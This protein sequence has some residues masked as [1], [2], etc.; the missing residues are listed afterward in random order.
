MSPKPMSDEPRA[1]C[2]ADAGTPLWFQV[3][4]RFLLLL[5]AALLLLSLGTR[6][7]ASNLIVAAFAVVFLAQGCA[8]FLYARAWFYERKRVYDT[9]RELSSIYRHL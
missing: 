9:R 7:Y 4:S 5:A 8:G 2:E 6:V 1:G 3:A